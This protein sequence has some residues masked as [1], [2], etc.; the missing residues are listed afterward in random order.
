M[1]ITSGMSIAAS[2][3][4]LLNMCQACHGNDGNS[5]FTSIPNLKWQNQAYMV[6]QLAQFKNGQRQD[7]TMSKVAKLLSTEQMEAIASYFHNGKEE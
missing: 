4:N 5:Q 1:V 2:D 7:K 6:Q 3:E